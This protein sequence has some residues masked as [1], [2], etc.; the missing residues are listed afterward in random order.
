MHIPHPK[1]L[2]P[3]ET[4]LLGALQGRLGLSLHEHPR[5]WGSAPA[6]VLDS[7]PGLLLQRHGSSKAQS[8]GLGRGESHLWEQQRQPVLWGEVSTPT[9]PLPQLLVLKHAFGV[10]SVPQGPQKGKDQKV[11]MSYVMNNP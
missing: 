5:R 2:T 9:D 10:G 6:L 8:P 3:L 4:F 11:G 7:A 1:K